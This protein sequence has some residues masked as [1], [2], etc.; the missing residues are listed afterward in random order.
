MMKLFSK[1]V[2]F[3]LS[4][5]CTSE[6]V[7]ENL[8][9]AT[10]LDGQKQVLFFAEDHD[11][12]DPG[13]RAKTKNQREFFSDFFKDNVL[14]C[15]DTVPLYLEAARRLKKDFSGLNDEKLAAKLERDYFAQ[16]Y[17]YYY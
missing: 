17:Y 5:V 10:S 2:L 6:S 16:Y 8:Y 7:I 9:V 15:P 13:K 4:V 14:G 3:L 11:Y 12:I 1:L